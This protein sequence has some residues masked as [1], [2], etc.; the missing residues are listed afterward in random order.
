MSGYNNS[1]KSQ[2]GAPITGVG[3]SVGAGNGLSRVNTGASTRSEIDVA[4]REVKGEL[5]AN[6]DLLSACSQSIS[7]ICF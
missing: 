2:G 5:N 7:R 4:P 6:F 1:G 3:G